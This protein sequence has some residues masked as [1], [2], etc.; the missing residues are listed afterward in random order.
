MEYPQFIAIDA[1]SF[2]EHAHP[3]AIAWSLADG[4]IKTTLISPDDDWEEDW[5]NCLQDLHGITPETLY[6]R[7]ETTWSVVRELEED[8]ANPYLY[9]DNQETVEALLGKLYES[10][11]RELN[12]EIGSF[13]EITTDAEL[14]EHSHYQIACDERVQQLLQNWA[15]QQ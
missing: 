1:S 15:A 7:G 2:E 14:D 5:D 3:V 9:A 8:L 11:N 4:Q 12:I 13:R 10:C 6:Q